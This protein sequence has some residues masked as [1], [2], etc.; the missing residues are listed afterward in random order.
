MRKEAFILS[1]LVLFSLFAMQG[2]HA[3]TACNPSVSLVNQDPYP[4]VPGDQV[5][6][7]FQID[8]VQNPECGNFQ[9]QLV[10]KYP[11]SLMPGQ[12]MSYNFTGGIF[13]KDYQSFFLAPYSVLVSPSALDGNN[14]IEVRY[15]YGNNA[16]WESKEFYLDVKDVRATFE[17]YV[18]NYNPTTKT[19]TLEILNTAKSN[20]K[21]VTLEIPQQKGVKMEGSNVN[22]VG[23][24]DSNDYTT[25]DFKAVPSAGNITVKVLYT[26]LINE[27][28]TVNETINFNPSYFEGNTQK[29]GPSGSTIILYLVIIG[30]VIYYFYSR[31]KKKKALKAKLN[32]K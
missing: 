24:L 12:Q 26:D 20:V 10:P 6:T 29:K 28:R 3:S 21:A 16:Y 9:F 18:K 25:A 5:K 27:R 13:Q 15:K 23:D 31:R 14:S 8:G 7:V 11:I 17:L 22:V 30:I 1:A 4:A 2:V 19:F 32:R